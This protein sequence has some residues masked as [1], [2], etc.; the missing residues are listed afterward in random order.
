MVKL[1]IGRRVRRWL[2]VA[3]VVL[4]APALP[5]VTSAAP[6][7]DVLA[8]ASAAPCPEVEV[9]FARGRT[10]PAG[11][12]TLGNAFVNALRSRVNKNIGVYAVRYPA[13]TEVDI[14]ANDMSGHVQY[15]IGN[16]PNTRLVLGGYSLGAAV[17]DVVLAVPF[18]AF[19][20]KSPLPADADGHIA[21]VALFGNGAGWV[22]P[23]TNFNPAYRDRTIELCHG[24]DPICNPADPDTW[25]NNWPDHL[26]GA[27]IDGGMVN[28]AADFV[29]G[30]L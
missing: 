7:V 30:R 11:V 22:G 15:M 28:Q 6:G 14:G 17:T 3:A 4:A 20:F 19:G 2:G 1:S 13:D 21:A 10:E 25:K 12:G 24:A 26:A 27:Y 5:I 23:I 16:C 9:V 29:A 18:T 8:V